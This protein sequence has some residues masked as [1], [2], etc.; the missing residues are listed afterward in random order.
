MDW[1]AIF[2]P[3]VNALEA[4]VILGYPEKHPQRVNAKRACRSCWWSAPPALLPNLRFT[5]FWIP[6]ARLSRDAGNAA[7]NRRA[8]QRPRARLV[9][10]EEAAG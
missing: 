7:I 2:R 3:M 8:M 9:E 6:A 10:N 4:M 5:A 1:G